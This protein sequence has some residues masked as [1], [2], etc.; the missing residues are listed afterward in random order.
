MLVC[1]IPVEYTC[2]TFSLQ[3]LGDSSASALAII[4]QLLLTPL[5]WFINLR[6][7]TIP[8]SSFALI[9]THTFLAERD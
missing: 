5:T 2:I 8:S 1:H 3:M 4:T 9:V 6:P 7:G